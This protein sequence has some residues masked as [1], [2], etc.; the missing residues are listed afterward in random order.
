MQSTVMKMRIMSNSVHL[1]ICSNCLRRG[2]QRRMTDGQ[3]CFE[4][5]Y[6]GQRGCWDTDWNTNSKELGRQ[7]NKTNLAIIQ[8]I[9]PYDPLKQCDL[10]VLRRK[11]LDSQVWMYQLSLSNH[12][13]HHHPHLPKMMTLCL[14]K[15]VKYRGSVGQCPGLVL[16]QS[17]RVSFMF[18]S[19]F[20]C[21]N[22]S[23]ASSSS[24]PLH[25]WQHEAIF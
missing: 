18:L 15:T 12:H 4:A 25:W 19:I 17:L 8:I 1:R 10:V 22:V 21:C 6:E 9:I 14:W 13:H 24:S 5:V 3:G 2:R 23:I 16:D 11:K 20:I 7:K